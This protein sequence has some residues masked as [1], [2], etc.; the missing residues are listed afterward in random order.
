MAKRSLQPLPRPEQRVYGYCRV[1]TDRQADS[2]ISLDEQERKLE[3]RCAEHGWRLEHVY[4]DAGVSGSTLLGKRP[5]GGRLLASLRPGD[6]VLAVRLDRMFRSA[7]DALNTIE[8]F[9]RRKIILVLLDLGDCTNGVSEL[10][11]TVLAAVSQFERVLISERI[12]A[13]KSNLRHHNKHQGGKRPFGWRYG[14]ATGTGKARD[15][16][17]DDAEQA[18]IADIVAMREGGR[19]LMDIRDTLRGQGF[20]ISHQS[21]ANIL[22]RREAAA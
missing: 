21:V 18:A 15:L 3:A 12:C 17:S 14:A 19:T 8:A 1:S 4:V 6:I 2:G 22:A 16:V 5:E 10:I 9:K 11:L 20:A 13:A 7:V